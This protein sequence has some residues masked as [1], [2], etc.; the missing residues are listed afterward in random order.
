VSPEDRRALLEFVDHA[1]D[2]LDWVVN[3]PDS[4]VPRALRASLIT[5]WDEAI[6]GRL[7]I[8]TDGIAS[9]QRD[10]DLDANGLSGPELEMKLKIFHLYYDAW[11]EIRNRRLKRRSR[12]RGRG[13]GVPLVSS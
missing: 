12:R 7:G 6:Q 13:P 8:L 4:G 5:A 2:L 10:S 9:G 3:D 11:S 1:R